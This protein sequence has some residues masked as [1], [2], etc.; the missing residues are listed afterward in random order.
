MKYMQLKEMKEK[1]SKD[2]LIYNYSK[3]RKILGKMEKVNSGS[4]HAA[5]VYLSYIYQQ[6]QRCKCSPDT[7]HKV[8]SDPTREQCTLVRFRQALQK[9]L[10]PNLIYKGLRNRSAHDAFLARK[11]IK[12]SGAF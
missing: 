8:R 7:T 12:Q 1:S 6:R 5:L 11:V 10:Q 2:L 3:A 4:V 9:R